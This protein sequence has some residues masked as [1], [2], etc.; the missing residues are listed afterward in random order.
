MSEHVGIPYAKDSYTSFQAALK[1]LQHADHD[2][3]AVAYTI[4]SMGVSGA[5]DEEVEKALRRKHQTVSARR[6]E[7]A[8]TG[9]IKRLGMRKTA[10][11]VVADVWVW[12]DSLEFD[13]NAVLEAVRAVRAAGR[14][15]RDL[16]PSREEIG[17]SVK[18]LESLWM[19]NPELFTDEL[20]KVAK[21][22]RSLSK[23]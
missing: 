19:R 23:E 8:K 7:L 22:L 4:F 9:L 11:D 5:T 6:N 3:V 18:A 2:S 16:K 1:A 14:A 12:E 10:S 20:S 17:A 13:E 21:W 15:K